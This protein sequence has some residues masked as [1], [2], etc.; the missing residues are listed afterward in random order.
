MRVKWI[1]AS[2]WF[3]CLIFSIKNKGCNIKWQKYS[4]FSDQWG[5]WGVNIPKPYMQGTFSGGG[6]LYRILV[7][8]RIKL[9]D[10]G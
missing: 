9:F 2:K 5:G 1:K 7:C 10:T 8:V 6:G 4:L 3:V